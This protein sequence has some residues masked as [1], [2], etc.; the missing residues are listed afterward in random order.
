MFKLFSKNAGVALLVGSLL[1]VVGAPA[2]AGGGGGL[3]YSTLTD[4]INFDDVGPAVLAGA[5]ALV[6]LY[7]II[8][9]VKLII[10]FARS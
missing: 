4:A 9:G 3:D 10:A 5:A 6:A 1:A 2:M 7:V 8:K